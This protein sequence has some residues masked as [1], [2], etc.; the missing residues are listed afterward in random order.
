MNIYS[1][2]LKPSTVSINVNRTRGDC[3]VRCLFS[4]QQR[5]KQIAVYMRPIF[6]LDEI[7]RQDAHE[8]L[9]TDGT[10][11]ILTEQTSMPSTPT[12]KLERQRT[13]SD[14][15]TASIDGD[16]TGTAGRPKRQHKIHL[17]PIPSSI[18]L[19]NT[20]PQPLYSSENDL[21]GTP[22]INPQTLVSTVCSSSI[23]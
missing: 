16:D 11:E 12:V 8:D 9:P 1:K 14:S 19:I 2:R 22:L 15:S 20:Q 7:L 5:L 10:S 23:P 21:Y 17:P 18:L 13:N 3:I 4:Y 6:E